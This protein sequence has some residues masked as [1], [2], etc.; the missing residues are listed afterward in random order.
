MELSGVSAWA[1]AV[2]KAAWGSAVDSSVLTFVSPGMLLRQQ[3]VPAGDQNALA[4]MC[5]G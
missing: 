1:V 5:C 4:Q 3:E 2:L